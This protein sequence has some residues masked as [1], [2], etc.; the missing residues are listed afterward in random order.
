MFLEAPQVYLNCSP[1]FFKPL[2]LIFFF[3]ESSLIISQDCSW[4]FPSFYLAW[5]HLFCSLPLFS[6]SFFF[7]PCLPFLILDSM[8]PWWSLFVSSYTCP[9]MHTSSGPNRSSGLRIRE[10]PAEETE[11]RQTGGGSGSLAVMVDRAPPA[12]HPS[13]PSKGKGKIS[14]IRYPS[15]YE[16]LKAVVKYADAVGPSRVEPLYEKTFVTR[17]RPPFGV[18]VWCPD[19]LTSY[20]VQVPKMICFFEAALENDIRFPLHPF[21]KNV[22]QHFNVCPSQLSPNFWGVLVGLLVVFRDKGLKVPSIALLLDL[23]SVKEAAEGFL[24]IS[25]RSSASLIISDLPSSHKHWNE[26]YFFIGGCNWEYNPTD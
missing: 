22:Y 18:Q 3:L 11:S 19:L 2:S 12:D 23:F 10:R 9:I 16:Y 21:I 26:R 13:P 20:I 4:W 15:G 25:K 17:Y 8:G 6:T 24:Y 5:G 1:L 14:E 7:F